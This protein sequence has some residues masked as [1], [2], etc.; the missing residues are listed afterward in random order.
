MHSAELH[1]LGLL[2]LVVSVLRTLSLV[3]L[4]SDFQ[5]CGVWKCKAHEF[6]VVVR[7]GAPPPAA[8]TGPSQ[9]ETLRIKM[10]R[11]R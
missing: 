3:G 7:S 2:V 1:G 6:K 8:G 9:F 11:C 10:D 4:E 5:G